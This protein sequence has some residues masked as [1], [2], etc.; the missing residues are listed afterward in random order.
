MVRLRTRVLSGLCLTVLAADCRGNDPELEGAAA[1]FF[2][3]I[4]DSAVAPIALARVALFYTCQA[5]FVLPETVVTFT[6]ESGRYRIHFFTSRHPNLDQ[7]SAK[8]LFEAAGFAA[9]SVLYEG[10]PFNIDGTRRDSVETNVQLL[11]P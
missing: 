2:G 6:D 10:V 3:Q 4:R 7:N 1:V 8:L 9:D 5:C 11:A